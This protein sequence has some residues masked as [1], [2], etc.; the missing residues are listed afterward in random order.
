MRG[1]ITQPLHRITRLVTHYKQ[2][3]RY[4]ARYE[5]CNAAVQWVEEYDEV[6]RDTA[7]LGVAID[8]EGTD[9]DGTC[10]YATLAVMHN[11][12]I[13][14]YVVSYASRRWRSGRTGMADRFPEVSGRRL[15]VQ[16]GGGS[17]IFCT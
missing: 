9:D 10:V 14:F 17:T 3:A 12:T 1:F 6:D 4:E 15:C 8:F 11:E 13:K 2:V 5:A 7:F 16:G